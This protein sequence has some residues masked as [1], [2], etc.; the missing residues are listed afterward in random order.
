MYLLEFLC[1]Q[2]EHQT[3]LGHSGSIHSGPCELSSEIARSV[4][5]CR[6]VTSLAFWPGSKHGLVRQACFQVMSYTGNVF[7]GRR[8]EAFFV[9]RPPR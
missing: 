9:T 3:D 7:P 6:T 5:F 1:C 4:W 8:K 2:L